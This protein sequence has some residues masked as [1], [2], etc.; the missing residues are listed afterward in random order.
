MGEDMTYAAEPT[1]AE[2]AARVAELET[3]LS[4]ATMETQDYKNKL[5]DVVNG[6]AIGQLETD[7]AYY[8][9][10]VAAVPEYIKEL[11]DADFAD[12]GEPSLEEWFQGTITED[13]DE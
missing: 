13:G 6:T 10:M 4:L 1:R 5:Q 9:A 2:L 12:W 11:V 7:L 8:K 3:A